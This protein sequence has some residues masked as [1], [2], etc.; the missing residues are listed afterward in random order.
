MTSLLVH[1]V[2]HGHDC[3]GTYEA[4]DITAVTQAMRDYAPLK[5]LFRGIIDT[6]IDRFLET[7]DLVV[8]K[9]T[10]Y[11][12]WKD[13]GRGRDLSDMDEATFRAQMVLAQARGWSD[14]I[15]IEFH[16]HSFSN[17]EDSDS[18]GGEEEAEL[19]GGAG[20]SRTSE[21]CGSAQ[22]IWLLE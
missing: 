20:R 10:S 15:R 1:F 9:T 11:F 17:E 13:N 3:L 7:S 4:I 19:Q 22:E 2:N 18:D 8:E 12:V 5:S 21:T 14:T 6:A 16:V